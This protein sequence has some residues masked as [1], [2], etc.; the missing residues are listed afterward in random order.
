MRHDED[1]QPGKDEGRGE[2][3]AVDEGSEAVSW[4][5][6]LEREWVEQRALA[7]SMPAMLLVLQRVLHSADGLP[8]SAQVFGLCLTLAEDNHHA[9]CRVV[10]R[11]YLAGRGVDADE[12]TGWQWVKKAA[13]LADPEAMLL[14]ARALVFGLLPHGETP[15]ATYI[16]RAALNMEP[17]AL[18]LMGNMSLGGQDQPADNRAEAYAWL[19]M[20]ASR[21]DAR[22]LYGLWSL[23]AG[24]DDLPTA[25]PWRTDWLRRAAER[26]H[27]PAQRDWGLALWR[28][29][30]TEAERS[31]AET[32]LQRA[33]LGGDAQ[34][35]YAM[36]IIVRAADVSLG[37]L[38]M[39]ARRGHQSAQLALGR[40][41][42][43]GA[44]GVCRPTEAALWLSRAVVPSEDRDSATGNEALELLERVHAGLSD[45]QRTEVL[46]WL[47]GEDEGEARAVFAGVGDLAAQMRDARGEA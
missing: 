10:G 37:W 35:A 30:T 20:G 40:A 18:V 28:A 39:A 1:E 32:W 9:A 8:D 15:P 5:P 17:E 6:A 27:T 3:D 38:V 2:E 24:A 16:Y 25:E 41:Y 22:A 11:A 19:S 44:D 21:D 45:A 12:A 29:A 43:D 14:W 13:D 34:S 4:T 23:T 7:G 42:A 36:S 26:G 47:S 46:G 33:A 31:D